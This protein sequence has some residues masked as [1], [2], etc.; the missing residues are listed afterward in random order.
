MRGTVHH[1]ITSMIRFC[2]YIFLLVFTVPVLAQEIINGTLIFSVERI[3]GSEIFTEDGTQ[4]PLQKTGIFYY[5][6]RAGQGAITIA[7]YHYEGGQIIGIAGEGSI[8]SENFLAQLR[9]LSLSTFDVASEIESTVSELRQKAQRE[10]LMFSLPTVFD[11]SQYRIYYQF[12]GAEIKYEAPNPGPAIDELAK[13]NANI[14]DLKQ[15]IDLFALQFGRRS[16]G[17]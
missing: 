16:F 1:S 10:G 15:L 7:G 4:I 12:N 2:L 6:Q 14:A 17:L 9:Q 5:V 11:G 8:D 3:G 13:H